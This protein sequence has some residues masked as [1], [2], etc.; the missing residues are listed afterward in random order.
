MSAVEF[1]EG[2]SYEQYDEIDALRASHI[3]AGLASMA[4][5][6]AA[7]DSEDKKET[8]A[9]RFGKIFHSA[10]LEPADY[11]SKVI[12][13]PDFGKGEGSRTKK[14]DW[15]SRIGVENPSAIILKNDEEKEKVE[16]MIRRFHDHAISRKVMGK[17]KAETVI[18]WTNPETGM[19]CKCRIDYWAKVMMQ[20]EHGVEREVILM[21][22]LKSTTDASQH[23]VERDAYDLA[24]DVAA[25]HYLEGLSMYLGFRIDSFLFSFV[26]KTLPYGCR[27]FTADPMFLDCGHERREHVM[28]QVKKS[29][30][31]K[32]WPCYPEVFSNLYLPSYIAKRAEEKGSYV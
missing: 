9:L 1:F 25:V 4:H 23:A 5:F 31:S 7:R 14:W 8:E 13:K 22:D 3:K 11:F 27:Y 18:V 10:L 12:V 16:E 32:Q 20:D 28:R 26:E 2:M 30:E 19:L 17:G 29:Q 21:M 24:Y 6:K 15:E